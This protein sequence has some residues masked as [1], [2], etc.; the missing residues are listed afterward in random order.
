ME[1]ITIRVIERVEGTVTQVIEQEIPA[2]VLEVTLFLRRKPIKE[3]IAYAL[4]RDGDISIER[5]K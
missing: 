1:R 4:L 2:T 3:L 5:K